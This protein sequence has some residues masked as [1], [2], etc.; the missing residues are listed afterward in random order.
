MP[1]LGT[2][3]SV[4]QTCPILLALWAAW[5]VQA[6]L[7][8]WQTY[9]FSRR[10]RRE[11]RDFYTGFR[12]HAVVIVP[13]KGLDVDL[14]QGVAS[15]CEQDY[16]GYE[17][18]LIVDS[19]DDPAYPVLLEQLKRYPQRDA[20][21]LIAGPAG[22]NEGQ[23]VHNQ[24]YAID[25]LTSRKD[26][27][28]DTPEAWVFADSDAVP[29]PQWLGE[30]VGPLVRADKVGVTTG[31]RWLVPAARAGGRPASVWSHLASVMNSSVAC[32]H[33]F[34]A[35][36]YAWGGSMA[37]L[38]QTARQG[39]LRG[40][41][42]GALC[43]DYQFSR[44]SRDLGLRIYFVPPCLVASPVDF[45][46]KSLVNF[47]HRQYLLTRVYAPGL[48]AAA[49]ALT[50]L[51]VAGLLSAWG[52]ILVAL[53][54]GAEAGAWVTPACF[55]AAVFAAN[56]AR[57]SCRRLV[58][59]AAFGPQMVAQLRTTLLWDRWATPLWMTLHWLLIVRSAFG[60]TMRWRGITYRLYAPQRVE[61][62]D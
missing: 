36:N 43:D 46:F 9:R 27:R 20:R 31:Y 55:G 40:R 57:A 35:L 49:V 12:P 50:S 38:A 60:R 41:L 24:L 51:Y 34:D 28:E 26:R 21:V 15:L 58:I 11:P 56:Q 33:R 2:I 30:M 5:V 8:A 4:T 1:E 52:A 39:D 13:F 16:P 53:L 6:A 3:S 42:V 25:Y 45:D 17:L 47:A 62:L 18:L 19:K 10:F 22:P 29:G 23:K 44:M 7:S 54:G 48:F 61:R 59:K 32:Q 37:L 14:A